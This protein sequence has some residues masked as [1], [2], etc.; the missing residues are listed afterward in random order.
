MDDILSAII[1][2][3]R[4]PLSERSSGLGGYE[5]RFQKVAVS[6]R[7]AKNAIGGVRLFLDSFPGLSALVR[8]TVGQEVVVR[9][10]RH[11]RCSRMRQRHLFRRLRVSTRA[12]PEIKCTGGKTVHRVCRLK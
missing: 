12:A 4:N 8:S 1:F 6:R 11:G 5:R 10:S 9:A 3:I 7:K 2:R